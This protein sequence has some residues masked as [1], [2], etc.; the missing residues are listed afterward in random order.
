MT[1]VEQIENRY[2]S[3]AAA[4]NYLGVCTRVLDHLT[5][6]GRLPRIKI[7]GRSAGKGRVLFDRVDLDAFMGA[8]KEILAAPN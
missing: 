1:N 2:F 8:N 3:R 5:R 4:A 7:E 6:T